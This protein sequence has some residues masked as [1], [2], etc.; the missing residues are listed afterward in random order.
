MILTY[1]AGPYIAIVFTISYFL[2]S[3]SLSSRQIQAK[4]ADI[5]EQL[6]RISEGQKTE[7]PQ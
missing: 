1:V 4:L 3:R 2:R 7:P 5:E 6:R